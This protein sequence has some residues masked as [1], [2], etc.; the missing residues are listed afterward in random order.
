[1]RV[2][3]DVEL[4]QLPRREHVG[5]QSFTADAVPA[6]WR[7]DAVVLAFDEALGTVLKDLVLWT[8]ATGDA[9]PPAGS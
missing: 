4:L 1:M 6:A 7:L 5:R 9:A 8:V 2:G 3:I